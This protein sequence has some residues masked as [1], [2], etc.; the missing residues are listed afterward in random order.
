MM[1]VKR[2]SQSALLPLGDRI[3]VKEIEVS[4][5]KKTDS[6]IYIPDSVKEDKGAKRGTVV[7]VGPGRY[8]DGKHTPMQVEV[9]DTILF[10]WGE[11]VTY[12]GAEYFLAR[13]GEVLAIIN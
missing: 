1:Q 8:E 11:Q 6:G 2:S 10:T 7:A 9:G 13:E 3:L 5:G 12:K 4:D